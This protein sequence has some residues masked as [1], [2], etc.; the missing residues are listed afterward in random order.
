MERDGIQRLLEPVQGQFPRLQHRW[1][2][3][4]YN[5]QGKGQD[6]VETT[7]GWTAESVSH[8]PRRR[9]VL[10]A[11]AVEVNWEAVLP[12]P[13]VQVLPWRWIV[14]RTF[15]WI[16]QSR[17]MRKDYDRRC[18]TSEP[19]IEVVMTRLMVRRLARG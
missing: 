12:R 13:G 19:W 2:D 8:P 18:A 9:R 17:R 14:D 1:R 5:G 6:W 4:A 3:A 16:D 10:V 7:L 11:E 15:G